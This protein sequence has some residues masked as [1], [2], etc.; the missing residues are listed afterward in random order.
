MSNHSVSG[1]LRA[2]RFRF[3]LEVSKMFGKRITVCMALLA[4]LFVGGLTGCA[5]IGQESYVQVRPRN[6]VIRTTTSFSGALR[7]MDDLFASRGVKGIPITTIGIPD[8]TGKVRAG[9]R[10]M[11]IT[12]IS[13]MS[14]HSG[15]FRYIDW[16]YESK[17]LQVIFQQVRDADKAAFDAAYEN[18]RYYIR[19]AVTQFDQNVADK[20]YGGGLVGQ[21]EEYNGDLVADWSA[22]ASVM[23]LDLNVGDIRARTIVPGLSSHN[24]LAIDRRGVGL[25]GAL[26]NENLG[27]TF[28]FQSTQAEGVHVAVRT[29]VELG[30]IETLGKLTRVPYWSCLQVESTA[31]GVRRELDDWWREMDEEE[32][33]LFVQRSLVAHGYLEG[34]ADG[35]RD[36]A[37]R[38][39]IA[40]YQ[41]ENG[42]LI[43]GR[44]N[45]D[46]YASLLGS[47][48][49]IAAGPPQTYPDEDEKPDAVAD[50][51]PVPEPVQLDLFT[52]R[53]REPIFAPSEALRAQVQVSGNAFVYCYYQEAGGSIMQVYPNRF[54][55]EAHVPAGEIVAVPGRRAGFQILPEL[56]LTEEQLMCAASSREIGRH[57]PGDLRVRDLVPMPIDSLDAL[58]DVLREIDRSTLTFARMPITLDPMP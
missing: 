22:A 18:P 11:L 32:Q 17:E 41:A 13:Q 3:A 5:G 49:P 56:G 57:L 25:G 23:G 19:G 1:V 37:T 14:E 12:T 15:A 34:Q 27:V 44:A 38:E 43:S 21:Y 26:A 9:M 48:R 7:C 28:D 36:A 24:S 55:P 4:S 58:S 10:D 2:K 54:Q 20:R 31:P 45:L 35:Q 40:R 6:E 50:A 42:L 53:G 46:L 30:T 52:D 39:A 16:E 8:A 51:L 47:D 33:M 29:L